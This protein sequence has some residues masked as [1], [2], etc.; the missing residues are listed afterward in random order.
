MCLDHLFFKPLGPTSFPFG[1][2]QSKA[3]AR[4]QPRKLKRMYKDPCTRN[5]AACAHLYQMSGTPCGC[6]ALGYMYVGETTPC[7]APACASGVCH[8]PAL[9]LSPGNGGTWQPMQLG[10]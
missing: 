9:M 10:R 2:S 4:T 3:V 6:S 5:P 7:R 1:R 8:L